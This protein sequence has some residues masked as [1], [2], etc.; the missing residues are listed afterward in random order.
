M[1]AKGWFGALAALGAAGAIT[2]F[3]LVA[4]HLEVGRYTRAN[5]LLLAALQGDEP[6]VRTM[7]KRGADPNEVLSIA[8]VGASPSVLEILIDAGG[9]PNWDGVFQTPL[10]AAAFVDR[11][12]VVSLLIRRGAD[13]NRADRRGKTPLRIAVLGEHPAMVR[14]LV[15][16]G[17]R[18]APDG[19]ALL[20]TAVRTGSEPMVNLLVELGVRPDQRHSEE[21]ALHVAAR[22]GNLDAVRALI[23]LGAFVHAIDAQGQTPLHVALGVR[24]EANEA[25]VAMLLRNGADLEARDHAGRT[26]IEVASEEGHVWLAGSLRAESVDAFLEA[27]PAE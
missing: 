18:V 20:Q 10:A 15:S 4:G 21:T 25:L 7:L 27:Q 13:P 16:L 9:D 3:L 2:G 12:D 5:R 1:N 22:H 14:H 6:T 11:Q 26:P 24:G 19:G 17:A 8:A 23:E